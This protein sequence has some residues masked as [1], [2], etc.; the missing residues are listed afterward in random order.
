[1]KEELLNKVKILIQMHSEGVLGGDSM[2][3]D[4]LT[5]VGSHTTLHC[6]APVGPPQQLLDIT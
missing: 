5:A 1:M 3:E 4:A 6:W 2:P